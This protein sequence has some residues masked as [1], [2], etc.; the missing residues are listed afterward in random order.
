[1]GRIPA[2]KAGVGQLGTAREQI[3]VAEYSFAALGGAVGS[4]ALRGDT[5][6][7]GAIIVDTLL[8]IDTIPTSG[9]AATI[10]ITTQSAADTAAVAAFDASPW[11]TATPKRGAI[12]RA[13]TPVRTTAEHTITAVIAAAALT[14]GRFRV[15]VTYIDPT[16]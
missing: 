1:M 13:T 11:S 9:G 12:T 8:I 16:A 3:A 15:L 6:P 14:A 7:S 4:I 5:I 2:G 10:G